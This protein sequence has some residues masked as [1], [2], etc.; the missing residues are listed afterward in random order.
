MSSDI[1]I[2]DIDPRIQHTATGSQTHFD[3]PFPIFNAEDLE[4]FQG[5]DLVPADGYQVAGVGTSD[6][7]TVTFPVA[8]PPPAGTTA[9]SAN[10][11]EER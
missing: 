4:V 2:G 8:S 6:G 7:G 1:L 11:A 9:S 10:T 5:D 3:F